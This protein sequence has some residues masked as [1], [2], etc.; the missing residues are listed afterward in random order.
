ME[1]RYGTGLY[2]RHEYNDA[3]VPYTTMRIELPW[4]RHTLYYS[5]SHDY[6]SITLT[7]QQTTPLFA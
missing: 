2:S 6:H 7:S 4:T 5:I 3:C 1:L